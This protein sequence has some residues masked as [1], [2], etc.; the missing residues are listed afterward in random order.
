LISRSSS[1]QVPN[2]AN[3]P[4]CGNI[5][6]IEYSATYGNRFRACHEG[7]TKTEQ[8][9]PCT[10]ERITQVQP[11]SP[12]YP[13]PTDERAV[14]L[15]W[16]LLSIDRASNLLAE[17]SSRPAGVLGPVLFPR[18]IR[19]RPFC[20]AGD[21]QSPLLLVLASH[22]AAIVL[23][24]QLLA[25]FIRDVLNQVAQFHKCLSVSA[26]LLVSERL[27]R[28]V[29]FDQRECALASMRSSRASSS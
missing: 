27:E 17:S 20:M 4:I 19:Q 29:C 10:L 8:W 25:A 3:R 22:R 28:V 23:S 9:T 2:S 11:V 24:S 6:L 1:I 26:F 12:S 18:C 14:A 15:L 21:W 13:A 16:P 5:L 7:S